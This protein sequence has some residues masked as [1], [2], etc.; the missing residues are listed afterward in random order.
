MQKREMNI[1]EQG[2]LPGHDTMVP[3]SLVQ[4][5]A[6]AYLRHGGEVQAAK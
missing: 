5:S 6:C 3:A 1:A 4:Y 2:R